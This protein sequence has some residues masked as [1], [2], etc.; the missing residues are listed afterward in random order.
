MDEKVEAL[1]NLI[2]KIVKKE[3]LLPDF[4][5]KF[6]WKEEEKQGR[7]I[8]S[9]L[10][11][12]P[13]GSILLLDSDAKDYAYKMLGCRE[14]KTYKELEM[15]G[16]ILALLD[17]QQR[18]TVLTNAFSNVIF[19]MAK[20]SSNLINRTGL[21]R[22]FFLRI[23]KYE[24]MEGEVEDFFQVRKLQFP[25]EDAE[26]EEPKFLSDDIY[27]A[28]KIISFNA[29]S[30]ECYNPFKEKEST[31]SDLINYCTSGKEYLIPLFWLTGKN[32]MGLSTVLKRI[33][34]NICL[35]IIEEYDSIENEKK[36][37]FEKNI[38]S[39]KVSE[40]MPNES[41]KEKLD[42]Q[43]SEWENNIRSY[44]VSCLNNIQL[45]Q[46]IV[47]NSKRARAI[48]IYENLNEGGVSLGTFEL[49]MARF[50][51]ESDENYY[52]KIEKYMKKKRKYP[53]AIYNEQLKNN[54]NVRA[55]LTS[56]KYIAT[57]DM[58]CIENKN[59]EPVN[60]YIDAYLN[61]MSL[62][63]YAG[64]FNPDDIKSELIKKNKILAIK[65]CDLKN[66]CEDVCDALDLALLFFKMRCG[67][68][69][70]KD[71][72]YKL[73]LVVV[74][75]ILSNESYREDSRTYDYLEAWYWISIFSGYYN[76]DQTERTITSIKKL[77]NTIETKNAEWLAEL[78]EKMFKVDY[79][80]EKKFLL[81]E[82]NSAGITPK[83]FFRDVVCQYY[84]SMTYK[85]L[86]D[87]EKEL[88]PFIDES[89]HKHHVIPLA[90]LKSDSEESKKSGVDLRKDDSYFLNSPFNFI[91]ITDEEN[92]DI[93]NDKLSD[94][95]KRIDDDA[96]KSI[97][98]LNGKICVDNEQECREVLKDRSNHFIGRVNERLAKLL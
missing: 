22:R 89:L 14:R 97:L 87:K 20:K 15:D 7:L 67:V 39:D 4:Q 65:P 74:S 35:D 5:R 45:H 11:K 94:Y 84:L 46:I 31:K 85:G 80:S 37:I 86:I 81:L 51:S 73:M 52:D 95:V 28:I 13:I 9:V 42:A 16:K 57:I 92:R 44:L 62:Y 82:M 10:A 69:S 12:M 88:N 75:Y 2:D 49:V 21:Q 3:I 83:S 47:D 76:S 36:S 78:K 34:E 68:R 61:V 1:S 18:V 53:E 63:S 30:D 91:Y 54:E 27:E 40:V 48:N 70:I 72:N 26:K 79:Y 23:P 38:I 43:A 55:K 17:G 77:I 24:R 93:L 90:S 29:N 64:L 56:E 71:I 8:A 59:G 25:L 19:D 60:T 41:F 50:A 96:T 98:G 6:I 32:T 58:G 66:K 33:S